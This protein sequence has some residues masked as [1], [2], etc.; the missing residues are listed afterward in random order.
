MM[1]PHAL[2]NGN[3]P[4]KLAYACNGHEGSFTHLIEA[5]ERKER[6]RERER[7]R[8]NNTL[9]MK[10]LLSNT[11][12]VFATVAVVVVGWIMW[13][14]WR[15]QTIS[16]KSHMFYFASSIRYE[17]VQLRMLVFIHAQV[18]SCINCTPVFEY[19]RFNF[20]IYLIY[21]IHVYKLLYPICSRS[22]VKRNAIVWVHIIDLFCVF[23]SIVLSSYHTNIIWMSFVFYIWYE[24]FLEVF[25]HTIEFTENNIP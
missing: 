25:D 1:G 5:A 2:Y 18:H 6:R 9:L 15:K 17:T 3:K 21:H 14:F 24:W 13:R 20:I 19:H 12:I 11:F 8:K 23:F 10:S 16:L 7:E 22:V 4:S